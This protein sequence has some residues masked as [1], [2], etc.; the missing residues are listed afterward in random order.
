MAFVNRN[1]N[2]TMQVNVTE[3]VC[4][5]NNLQPKAESIIKNK[6]KRGTTGF[7]KGFAVGCATIYFSGFNPIHEMYKYIFLGTAITFGTINA[8]R[9]IKDSEE[10]RKD[11]NHTFLRNMV[12][13][14][15]VSY[16][17]TYME[18][19]SAVLG[20]IFGTISVIKNRIKNIKE[21]SE[22]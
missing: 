11:D 5:E 8:I 7:A 16:S 13:V 14:S 6:L 18:Y 2:R 17:I 21:K 9:N 1:D 20:A 15:I 22:Q 19:E 10:Q 4:K 12:G 3:S